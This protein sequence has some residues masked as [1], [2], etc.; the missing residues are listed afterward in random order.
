MFFCVMMHTMENKSDTQTQKF[1]ELN[2]RKIILVGTA[3]V[4]AES[5]QEVKAAIENEKPDCVAVE[6]DDD[7]RRT[8]QDPDA[9]LKMDI[10]KVLKKK[11][12]LMMLANIILSNYQK[13]MGESSGVKPGYEMLA[14]LEKAEELGIPV[15]MVDRP[16]GVTLRRAWAKN[17]FIGK[18]KLLSVLLA[19]AFS[20]EEKTSAEEIE[21][22]KVNSEMDSMMTELSSYLPVVKEV[23]IDERDKFLASKIWETKGDKVLAVLGSGHLPGVIA[24]LEKIAAE[25]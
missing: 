12:G 3:H 19:S 24:H 4:S 11:M 5:I 17:S 21:K 1:L 7:R 14:A 2:G 18:M 13:K 15:S 10:I 22:L 8:L 23:L 9:F 16:I 25:E 20:K 6:L